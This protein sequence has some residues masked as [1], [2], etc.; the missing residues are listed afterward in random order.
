MI[1]DLYTR[2]RAYNMP[3]GGISM[4]YLVDSS[5]TL[6]EGRYNTDNIQKIKSEL[7]LSDATGI[8]L[9]H[10]SSWGA[11]YCNCREIEQLL[12]DLQPL[13]VE[14]PGYDP[15]DENGKAC[16]KI[17][18][19]YCNKSDMAELF[20]CKPSILMEPKDL[21]DIDF[22]DIIFSPLKTYTSLK[23]NTVVKIFRQGG[24]SLLNVSQCNLANDVKMQLGNTGLLS[25][26]DVLI[27]TDVYSNENTFTNSDFLDVVGPDLIVVAGS[28]P[29]LLIKT[30]NKLDER[31]IRSSKTID[32]DI[33]VKYGLMSR[34]ERINLE[35]VNNA[36]VG[37]TYK[38]MITD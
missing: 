24:F 31:G 9:L 35:N 30:E 34:K 26:V 14:V 2:F 33:V 28:Q 16:R 38:K 22:T 32:G 17:I 10:L 15:E 18:R 19:E 3:H 21:P 37:K 36:S 11:E 25:G 5:L 12:T 6:I 23:D 27:A 13:E 20:E 29:Q 7:E 8:D 4:S 1:D